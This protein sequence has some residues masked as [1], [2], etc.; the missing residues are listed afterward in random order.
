MNKIN[1]LANILKYGTTG[2]LLFWNFSLQSEINDLKNR[3]FNCYELRINDG[4]QNRSNRL[5]FNNN[6][7][8]LPKNN[9]YEN[10]KRHLK[11]TR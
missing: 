9:N 3:L 4:R 2:V 11:K 6:L 8:I 5:S 1:D 10:F 7:A